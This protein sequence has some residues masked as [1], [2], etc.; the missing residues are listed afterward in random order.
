MVSDKHRKFGGPFNAKMLLATLCTAISLPAQDLELQANP[1][2][3]FID[4][5]ADVLFTVV[6]ADTTLVPGSV[7][8]ERIGTSG[9]VISD[10]G[11]MYDDGSHGDA[12]AGDGT[13]SR[14]VRCSAIS[15]GTMLFR[16]RAVFQAGL[17]QSES[18]QVWVASETEVTQDQYLLGYNRE[19]AIDLW[20]GP[21]D[22]PGLTSVALRAS[23]P[24]GPWTE[25]YLGTSWR[26]VDGVDGTSQDWFYRIEVINASGSIIRVAGPLRVRK[27]RRDAILVDGADI[28]GGPINLVAF[29]NALTQGLAARGDGFRPRLAPSCPIENDAFDRAH[30]S[31]EQFLC[32][33]CMSLRHIRS[34]LDETGSFLRGQIQDVDGVIIDPAALIYSESVSRGINPQ[35]IVARLQAE[36]SAIFKRVRPPD[37]AL[38]R[39]M[40]C[41]AASTAT[42]RVRSGDPPAAV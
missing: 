25:V 31:D 15:V 29:A 32:S 20:W 21:E 19:V 17:R 27:S 13:Y 36:Q 18:M 14:S 4:N 40:G 37:A 39:L 26:S 6:I 9:S 24:N 11:V 33:S 34:L 1:K 28:V 35:L 16:A 8:L 41:Q 3:L 23:G 7:R 10:L 2:R 12:Q 38:R 22:S 42:I 5:P 30:L